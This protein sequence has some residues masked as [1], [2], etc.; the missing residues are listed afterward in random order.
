MW[1]GVRV[2]QWLRWGFFAPRDIKS[3]STGEGSCGPDLGERW[4]GGT[5]Y[6]R[7]W[8]GLMMRRLMK[9]KRGQKCGGGN[10]VEVEVE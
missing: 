2:A 10:R 3:V 1:D 8:D 9:R 4:L 7:W 5:S 6:G